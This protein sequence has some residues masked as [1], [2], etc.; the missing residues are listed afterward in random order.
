MTWQLKTWRVN[1]GESGGTVGLL[2]GYFW[3]DL[4]FCFVPLAHWMPGDMLT[5]NKQAA[6]FIEIYWIQML[7]EVMQMPKPF[8]AGSSLVPCHLTRPKLCWHSLNN[9]VS[10]P[11][12]LPCHQMWL[13]AIAFAT[14]SLA[15]KLNWSVNWVSLF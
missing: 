15:I 5:L 8:A 10:M 7:L 1:E 11:C 12:L 3:A 6:Q 14:V 2:Q 4:S 9:Y 13:C